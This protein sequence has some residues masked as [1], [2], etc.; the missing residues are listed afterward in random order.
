MKCRVIFVIFVLFHLSVC[1]QILITCGSDFSRSWTPD[2]LVRNVLLAE[3]EEVFNVKYNGQDFNSITCNALG[4]FT[5]GSIQTNLGMHSGVIMSTGHVW[6]SGGPNNSA[7]VSSN[8]TICNEYLDPSLSTI[9]NN[10]AKHDASTLE[11]D[12]IPKSDTIRFKYVFGS[13]EYLLHFDLQYSP[14]ENTLIVFPVCLTKDTTDQTSYLPLYL[15]KNSV[16]REDIERIFNEGFM[17]R[18]TNLWFDVNKG[19]SRFNQDDFGDLTI[20]NRM[21]EGVPE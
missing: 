2:S 13:E 18:V 20:I 11:L 5:T 7:S 14:T 17:K 15:E 3:G 1:S 6:Q 19:Q 21:F 4:F 12:F 8:A 9:N 16:T 10:P